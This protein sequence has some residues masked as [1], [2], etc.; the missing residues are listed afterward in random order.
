[1]TQKFRRSATRSNNWRKI[2]DSVKKIDAKNFDSVKKLTQKIS[3]R[4]KNWRKNFDS[5]KKLQHVV[6]LRCHSAQPEQGCQMVFLFL[7]QKN[8]NL[9]KFLRALDWKRLIYFMAIKYILR[10]L[11][12]FCHHL[13]HFVFIWYILSGLGIMYKE[14]SGIPEPE[15]ERCDF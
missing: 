8:P 7:K 13:V 15:A 6:F 10:T 5:V 9:G 2:F 1:M 3:T 12:I 11:G 4:S 14:K